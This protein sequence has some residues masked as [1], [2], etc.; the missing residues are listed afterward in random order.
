MT[1]FSPY[2]RF[3]TGLLTLLQFSVILDL[4]ILPPLGA[5]IMPA[6]SMS[7]GEF[8]TV[9]S[10]YA[11]SA[12]VSGLAMAGFADRYDRK[13]FLLVLYAGFLAGTLLCGLAT[14]FEW[15]LA[16]RIVTGLFGGVIGSIVTAIAGDLFALEQRGRVMGALQ[17]G[18]AASQI[19]GL[20][21]GL[22]LASRW[23]WQSAFYAVVALGLL[24]SLL[25]AFGLKPV[26]EHLKISKPQEAGRHLLEAAIH[27]KYRLPFVVTALLPTGGFMLMPFASAFA[28]NNIGISMEEL[29]MVYL[30][31]GICAM[32]SAQLIGRLTDR[33][34]AK[35]V[36]NVGTAMTVL[37][38]IVYTN[39]GPSPLWQ[40]ILVN[41]VM[42][43]GIFG[44][45][46]PWQ[47]TVIGIPSPAQ[48]GVF[49]S[50]NSALQQFAGGLASMLAGHI[51]QVET[52]GKLLNIPLV[53]FVVATVSIIAAAVV[54]QILKPRQVQNE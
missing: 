3:A 14:S 10:A 37:M 7:P 25:I 9:V 18:F 8:G 27:E 22:M 39:M 17:G 50:I 1:P 5:M 21:I 4:M 23:G 33:L 45:M 12:G 52:G 32:V 46:I 43:T 34:G 30:A 44:R 26:N 16:A 53:G 49:S 15:L 28:V 41:V 51:V 40:L 19:L 20:P 35:L 6:L 38:V 36:F 54:H 48:R 13:S 24:G 11:F 2:Q 31:C 42:F 47:A 29:P